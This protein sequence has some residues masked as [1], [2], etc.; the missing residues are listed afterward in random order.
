LKPDDPR[1]PHW[2]DFVRV[3]DADAAAAKAADLGGRVVVPPRP[4]RQGGKLAVVA[5]PSGALIGLMQW[6]DT[7]PQKEQQP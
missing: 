7:G 5:D 2:L 6:S 1:H 3:A 4:D